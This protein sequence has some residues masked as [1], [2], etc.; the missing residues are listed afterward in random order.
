MGSDYRC[1]FRRHGNNIPF[2]TFKTG[3]GS[4]AEPRL[5]RPETRNAKDVDV[6]PMG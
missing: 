3:F 1:R 6:A 2:D 4:E 5:E